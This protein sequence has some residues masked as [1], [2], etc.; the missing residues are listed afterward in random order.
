MELA[1]WWPDSQQQY[2]LSLYAR[3]RRLL[4]EDTGGQKSRAVNLS[5]STPQFN[6]QSWQGM[7]NAMS[8]LSQPAACRQA[9]RPCFDAGRLGTH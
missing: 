9:P 4:P 3:K 8:V 1:D 5:W 7:G 6:E 2:K